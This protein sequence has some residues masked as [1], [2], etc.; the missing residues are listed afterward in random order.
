MK[1]S[2]KSKH[3]KKRN[4]AFLYEVLIQ[5][6]TRSVVGADLKRKQKGIDICKE[7]FNRN[8]LLSQERRIFSSLQD[9]EKVEAPLADK[10]VAE[11]KKEYGALNKRDIFNEQTRL[12][13]RI[14]KD[15]TPTV[16]SHFVSHYKNLATIAQ[17]LNQ[18][19]PVKERVLLENR[20]VKQATND[21]AHLDESMKPTDKL[22]YSTFVKNYNK[23]YE[24][25]LLEEQKEVITRHAIAFSDNGLALKRFLNEELRRLKQKLNE[26]AQQHLLKNNPSLAERTTEVIKIL[27][28]F[29]TMPTFD[30]D[31]I[32]QI[33]EI[34]SLV[35]EME[36]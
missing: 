19:L 13:R 5:D 31:S 16:F 15:L 33:L 22:V 8:S 10:I 29:K 25:S 32:I 21:T 34:Q 27:E 9:M 36:G 30:G 23:K 20:F 6:I 11:A 26:S 1:K 18:E 3:N 35:K 7:F 4:T 28:S 12:I 14:N 17:I 24:D 2:H